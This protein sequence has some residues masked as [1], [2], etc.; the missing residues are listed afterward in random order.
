MMVIPS[1]TA[2]SDGMAVQ[3]IA[4]TPVSRASA[5]E[6]TGTSW[7]PAPDVA[8]FEAGTQRFSAADWTSLERGLKQR[9]EAVSACLHELIT[10]TSVPGF[11]RESPELAVAL[12]KTLA[13]IAGISRTDIL[14]G[15]FGTTDFSIDSN[16][17]T[18]VLDHDFSLPTGL[19]RLA[20]AAAGVRQ[21]RQPPAPPADPEPDR[22]S[23]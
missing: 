3:S 23:C 16:G 17:E 21:P 6:E 7:S 4:R 9:F 11:L 8:P 14:W 22:R 2:V 13:P 5:V 18:L 12:Q 19:E 15:W 20:G 10:G 1:A